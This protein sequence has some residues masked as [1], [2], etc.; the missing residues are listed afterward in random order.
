M[1][2]EQHSRALRALFP[3]PLGASIVLNQIVR[4]AVDVAIACLLALLLVA[5]VACLRTVRRGKRSR[6][7]APAGLLMVSIMLFV[8]GE[9]AYH[10]NEVSFSPGGWLALRWIL[11]EGDYHLWPIIVF[12]LCTAGAVVFAVVGGVKLIRRVDFGPRLYRLEAAL[13]VAAAGCI[14]VALVSTLGWAGTLYIRAPG[15]LTTQGLGV[16][17]SPLLPVL[18]L[19]IVVMAGAGALATLSSRRCFRCLAHL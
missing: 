15:F 17:G 4:V 2:L 19:A 8:L 3:R 16:L 14:A 11:T 1:T 9:L 5:V 6:L 18:L 7:F 12:P 10:S 13:A